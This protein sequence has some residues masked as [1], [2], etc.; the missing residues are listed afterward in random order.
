MKSNLFNHIFGAVFIFSNLAFSLG[1]FGINSGLNYFSIKS[2]TIS[3]ININN[4][5]IAYATNHGITNGLNIG[6]YSYINLRS[7]NIELELSKLKK[8]YQFTFKNKLGFTSNSESIL[9]NI[10]FFQRTLFL[11]FNRYLKTINYKSYIYSNYFLGLGLGFIQSTPVVDNKLFKNNPFLFVFDGSGN[12]NLTG[13]TLSLT[14]LRDQ[15]EEK[16]I[17]KNTTS[18]SLQTGYKIRLVNI[19]F[20]VFY[21]YLIIKEILHPDYQNYGS[22]NLRLGLYI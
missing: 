21:R 8:E 17:I 10:D 22:F 5:T 19:E 6:L 12:P 16:P 11:S 13:G 7:G 18:L 14:K 4:E 15:I 20:S 2:S 1:G 3:N 9:Y